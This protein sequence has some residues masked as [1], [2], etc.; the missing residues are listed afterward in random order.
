M[1]AA[2][3]VER[4][5]EELWALETKA[6]IR[7]KAEE[8]GM[9]GYGERE[10]YRELY[11]AVP[12]LE[13][14]KAL[15]SKML[16]VHRGLADEDAE[17]RRDLQT[18]KEQARRAMDDLPWTTA[19][20]LALLCVG[21]GSSI[22]GLTGAIGGAVLGLFLGQGTISNARKRLAETFRE[23]EELARYCERER[24]DRSPHFSWLEASTGVPSER[25]P[26]GPTN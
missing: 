14:R 5:K 22:A 21:V 18:R 7:D 10:G 3:K 20:V 17:Y 8:Y 16:E 4:L 6:G 19:G 11:F 12:D 26:D 1:T 2:E 23:A 13:L 9:R 24:D 25:E 15:I